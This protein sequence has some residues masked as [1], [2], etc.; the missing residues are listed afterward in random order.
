MWEILLPDT[1]PSSLVA[2]TTVLLLNAS[3]RLSCNEVVAVEWLLAAAP[4]APEAFAFPSLWESVFVFVMF[5]TSLSFFVIVFVWL[6]V[7]LS[8]FTTAFE[9]SDAAALPLSIV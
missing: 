3:V 8:V 7:L 5:F 9:L 1:Y 4:K 2:L 6:S